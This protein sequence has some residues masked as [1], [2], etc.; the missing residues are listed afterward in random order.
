MLKNLIPNST[1][2]DPEV[3]EVEQVS[4]WEELIIIKGSHG[5]ISCLKV[6]P[7]PLT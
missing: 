2:F 4:Q 7:L 1:S 5:Q 3:C 6:Y